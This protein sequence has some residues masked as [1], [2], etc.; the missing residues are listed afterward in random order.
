MSIDWSALPRPV[1]NRGPWSLHEYPS[2]SNLA[3]FSAQIGWIGCRYTSTMKRQSTRL[4]CCKEVAATARAPPQGTPT[5]CSPSSSTLRTQRF[6][7][8]GR[9]SRSS[10]GL[11]TWRNQGK[12]RFTSREAHNTLAARIEPVGSHIWSILASIG[13]TK[14]KITDTLKKPAKND[15]NLGSATSE[16]NSQPRRQR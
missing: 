2:P 8:L 16:V 4:Y 13:H 6:V 10:K 9:F 14:K 5:G 11:N 3:H 15:W 7:A 1:G 12:T